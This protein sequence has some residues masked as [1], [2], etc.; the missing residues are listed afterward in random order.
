MKDRRVVLSILSLLG[1]AAH[2]PASAIGPMRSDAHH[3]NFG[4]M[5]CLADDG[6]S[7]KNEKVDK[8]L[9]LSANHRGFER[10]MNCAPS[11]AG[12]TSLGSP[13]RLDDVPTVDCNGIDYRQF[14]LDIDS[15]DA[16]KTGAAFNSLKIYLSCDADLKHAPCSPRVGALAFDLCA[17]GDA[18]HPLITD[19]ES[20]EGACH[21]RFLVD[22]PQTDF[23]T[24]DA[25]GRD[26]FVYL[27]SCLKTA[28]R[29]CH[30]RADWSVGHP[31]DP[32]PPCPP[33]ILP[34]PG[35]LSTLC[36]G[37]LALKRRRR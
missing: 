25:S 2:C 17:S 9:E 23:Q 33:A 1:L 7:D 11:C 30:S 19:D 12:H 31:C 36:L 22:I 16:K 21:H 20:D 3:A 8:F 10:G 27:Y 26:C 18:H 37:L 28:D 6:E 4:N 5:L 35:S 32:C 29:T 34:E 24:A 15:P 13:L 14:I